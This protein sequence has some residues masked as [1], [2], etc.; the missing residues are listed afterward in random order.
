MRLVRQ[1]NISEWMTMERIKND[2]KRFVSKSLGDKGKPND[3]VNT[4]QVPSTS[5][6]EQVLFKPKDKL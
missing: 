6:L 3:A 4:I 1:L 5:T 2:L